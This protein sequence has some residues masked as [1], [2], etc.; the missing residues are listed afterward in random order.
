MFVIFFTSIVLTTY[1]TYA[2]DG[3]FSWGGRYFL[4]FLP[5]FILPIGY[6]LEKR[7]IIIN[8]SIALLF[9]VSFFINLIGVLV[10]YEQY[11]YLRQELLKL[12]WTR[13]AYVSA[14][15]QAVSG[16]NGIKPKKTAVIFGQDYIKLF[17]PDIIAMSIILK[18]KI[19]GDE[20]YTYGD[21]GLK[22]PSAEKVTIIGSDKYEEFKG[23]NLWYTCFEDRAGFKI[24]R[25]F[26]VISIIVCLLFLVNFGKILSEKK[27][28]FPVSRKNI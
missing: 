22:Y 16:L 13:P 20:Y 27:D 23:L 7:K 17:P 6:L 26:P 15:D 8:A 28:I 18:K 10:P 4:I 25:F 5:Y 1:N 2:E 12:A 24:M 14:P 19:T 3:P 11:G 21:F 9:T